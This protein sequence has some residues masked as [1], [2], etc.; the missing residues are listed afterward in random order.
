[1]EKNQ[2]QS[3]TWIGTRNSFISYL[4]N[5]LPDDITSLCKIFADDTSLFS[6]VQDINRSAD[7]LNCN[8]EKVS[9]WAY[10]WKMQF[11]FDPNKQANE[12]ILSRKYNS[13][14]FPCPPVKFNKKNITK[15]SYQKHLG[16]VLDL[17]LNFN[18]HIDQKTKK[19]NNK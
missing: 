9:N 17:K 15:I 13:N 6:K 14:S 5:D 12:I 7:E 8:L 3:S 11:N 4:H 16:I 18:T 1:M 2:F 10:Q 19:C